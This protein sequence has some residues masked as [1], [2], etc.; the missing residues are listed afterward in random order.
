MWVN[1]K[2]GAYDVPAVKD[3][4]Q[5]W[6]DGK[7]LTAL[8]D[9]LLIEQANLIS[10]LTKAAIEHKREEVTAAG[11]KILSLSG[12]S[13]ADC[14]A[15]IARAENE[16]RIPPLLDAAD[17][18]ASPN[19]QSVM[20]YVAC[21]R[22]REQTLAYVQEQAALEPETEEP[23][24]PVPPPPAQSDVAAAVASI[25][26]PIEPVVVTASQSSE[27][28]VTGSTSTAMPVSEERASG[29]SVVMV[30]SVPAQSDHSDVV[31]TESAETVSATVAT[32]ESSGL[33]I[34]PSAEA[35]EPTAHPGT[36][37]AAMTADAPVLPAAAAAT[38]VGVATAATPVA[39]ANFSA[40]TLSRSDEIKEVDVCMTNVDLQYVQAQPDGS[41]V[42]SAAN[43]HWSVWTVIDSQATD[44]VYFRDHKGR[45]ITSDGQGNVF[46]APKSEQAK[47]TVARGRSQNFRDANGLFLTAAEG[48]VFCGRQPGM[49]AELTL[50]FPVI[51]GLLRK[52]GRSGLKRWQTRYFAFNGAVMSYWEKKD[53]AGVTSVPK[54]L[55]SALRPQQQCTAARARRSPIAHCPS[56][57]PPS[58]SSLCSG[59]PTTCRLCPSTRTTRPSSTSTSRTARPWPSTPSS[60]PSDSGGCT[61]WRWSASR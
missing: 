36:P 55:W 19:E 39:V 47:W 59:T 51:E 24:M 50:N 13:L 30:D 40:P 28:I 2:I 16:L 5:S 61:R 31:I 1:G 49:H 14:T 27:D 34:S 17:L 60:P 8:T 58:S 9:V 53:D 41:L 42:V 46:M 4:T 29:P 45:Y 21:F 12:D 23:P 52:K 35:S 3:F 18:V 54:N 48:R 43:T 56:P 6:V 11:L 26:E 10:L 32:T 57:S 44:I 22:D 33:H 15:A 38:L 37:T 7:A 20:T 25:S